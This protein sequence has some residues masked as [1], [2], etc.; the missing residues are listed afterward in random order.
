MTIFGWASKVY[1]EQYSPPQNA[2][3]VYVVGKQWMWK[4]QHSTG[5]REINELHVPIGRKIKLIMT[6]ED[7]I[8]SFFVP[9]FRMKA[10]VVPGKYT[11][12]WFEATK[13]G[14]FH[15]FCAEYCGMNHSGMIGSVTVSYTHLRAHETGR[16]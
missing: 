13:T 3:E 4:I 12:Q 9:A 6:T 1:F 10:D 8:H 5:Q 7:V 2:V 14:T 16:N 15:L 11:T